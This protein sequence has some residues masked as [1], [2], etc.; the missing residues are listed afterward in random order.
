MRVR[1]R[2]VTVGKN[3]PTR[4]TV[5][6]PEGVDPGFAYAPGA[7]TWAKVATSAAT[8]EGQLPPSVWTDLIGSA[9]PGA[10]RPDNL[11]PA[12]PLETERAVR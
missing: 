7:T 4:R 12:K 2:K 8:A 3:G 10:G 5:H 1:Y 9:W 6:V 11:V